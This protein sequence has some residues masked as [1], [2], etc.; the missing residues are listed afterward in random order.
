VVQ[1]VASFPSKR[2]LVVDDEPLVT[3]FVG[4]VL[5]GAGYTVEIAAS[6][7]EGLRVFQSGPWDLVI[8]D[9]AM[10]GMDG[11]ALAAAIRAS[12]S[13]VP[14]ILQTG[15]GG[16]TINETLFDAVLAKPVAIAALLDTVAR[17]LLKPS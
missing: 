4:A 10:P 13:D 1:D 6:G 2:I 7:A 11:E 8:T 16:L 3:G 14:I 12:G 5:R 17:F 15:T 9:R